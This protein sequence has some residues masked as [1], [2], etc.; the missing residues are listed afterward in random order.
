MLKEILKFFDSYERAARLYP[1]LVISAPVVITCYSFPLL[2]ENPIIKASILIIPF[3]ILMT[4]VVRFYGVADA[5]DKD[6]TAVMAKS[7]FSL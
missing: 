3:I 1:A 5:V 4:Y 6:V 2:R 7:A